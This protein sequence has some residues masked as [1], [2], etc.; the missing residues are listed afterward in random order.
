L[1]ALEFFIVPAKLGQQS[2][3]RGTPPRLD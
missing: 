1:R 2:L 3:D